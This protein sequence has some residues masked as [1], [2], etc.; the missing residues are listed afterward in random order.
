MFTATVDVGDFRR[1]VAQTQQRINMTLVT[2]VNAAVEAGVQEAKKGR[3]KDRTGRLRREIHH[4]SVRKSSAEVFSYL[5]SA[6]PYSRFV[7]YGTKP[8]QIWPKA[9]HGAMGP[10][11]P[12]QSRRHITDIGTHRVAL[13]WY[14]NGQPVFA[15]MV[16]HRGSAPYPYMVPAGLYAALVLRERLFSG[17]VG[18]QTVWN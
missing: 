6:T 14:V 1:R 7:E 12:G 3:F 8:H 11:M 9:G 2:A 10:L 4:D 17:F 18:L 15:R 13:R 5:I 16:H